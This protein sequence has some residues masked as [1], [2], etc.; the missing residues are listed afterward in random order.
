MHASKSVELRDDLLVVMALRV[1]VDDGVLDRARCVPGGRDLRE[2]RQIIDEGHVL[3]AEQEAEEIMKIGPIILRE[4][5]EELTQPMRPKQLEEWKVL[6]RKRRDSTPR[7]IVDR[8][9]GVAL[10]RHAVR[11]QKDV[12][13]KRVRQDLL[14]LHGDYSSTLEIGFN[15]RRTYVET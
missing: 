4:R 9:G 14:Q 11:E 1:D 5:I 13:S 8:G 3:V 2:R 15:G 6:R 10:D 7:E 12:L